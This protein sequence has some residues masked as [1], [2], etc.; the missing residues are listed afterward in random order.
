[1]DVTF[2][3][4]LHASWQEGSKVWPAY[5]ALVVMLIQLFAE[6]GLAYVA[7]AT[8]IAVVA[9]PGPK[10]TAEL[11]RRMSNASLVYGRRK[12]SISSN[13]SPVEEHE[14]VEEMGEDRPLLFHKQ[15]A[16]PQS[17]QEGLRFRGSAGGAAPAA[18]TQAAAAGSKDMTAPPAAPKPLLS[19][20]PTV[21]ESP[22]GA[23]RR[24]SGDTTGKPDVSE[25]D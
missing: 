23:P 16:H 3:A 4:T 1:V 12:E 24:R 9:E 6:S 8:P 18:A 15:G 7:P 5:T 25:E 14:E 20:L 13:R 10:G 21:P 17:L 19:A 2:Y 22:A 11:L